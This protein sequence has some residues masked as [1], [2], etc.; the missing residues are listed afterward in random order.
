MD[1]T[2][3]VNDQTTAIR[4]LIA[5][6]SAVQAEALRR[7]LAREGYTV[8]VAKDGAEGLAKA[9]ELSPD[10]MISDIMMPGMDGF[11]L[12]RNIKA[13]ERLRSTPVILLT[14]LSDP[15]DVIRAVQCGA[16]KFITKPYDEKHLLSTERESE[17]HA[18][19][20]NG[21]PHFLQ[22]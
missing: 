4:I 8:S 20:S 9:R 11:E 13:N 21:H 16:D 5:E 19:N 15:Q 17:K 6:D 10:L 7:V 3:S 12:C 2:N 18:G 1:E 22:G 14:S